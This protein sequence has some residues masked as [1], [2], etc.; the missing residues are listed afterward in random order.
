MRAIRFKGGPADGH[1]AAIEE[2]PR[3]FTFPIMPPK[4]QPDRRMVAVYVLA[5]Q[6]GE[7]YYRYEGETDA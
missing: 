1:I 3:E 5:R 4:H 2:Q 6:K 7:A